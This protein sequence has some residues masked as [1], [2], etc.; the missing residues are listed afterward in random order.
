MKQKYKSG[1]LLVESDGNILEVMGHSIKGHEYLC[2][3]TMCL[4]WFAG[5]YIDSLEKIGTL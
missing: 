1:D 5:L 3:Y 2:H 4:K